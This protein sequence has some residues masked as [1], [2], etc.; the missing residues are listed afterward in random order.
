[1]SPSIGDSGLQRTYESRD[2]DHSQLTVPSRSKA[3]AISMPVGPPR[4]TPYVPHWSSAFIHP[5]SIQEPVPEAMSQQEADEALKNFFENALDAEKDDEDKHA[6]EEE[7]EGMI[8]G[9]K[10]TL[11]KHQIEGLKFLQ[12]HELPRNLP[13][14]SKGKGKGTYGGILADD[15]LLPLT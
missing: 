5:E 13:T 3:T 11:M 10:V 6:V 12:D 1:M 9:L 14:K 7:G 15:V 2:M 8:E 4:P